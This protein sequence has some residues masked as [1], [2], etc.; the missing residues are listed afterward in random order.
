MPRPPSSA[1]TLALL[2]PLL[3]LAACQTPS[4]PIAV[5][6]ADIRQMILGRWYREDFALDGEAPVSHETIMF[7]ADG[8]CRYVRSGTAYYPSGKPAPWR[9]EQ[10]G[11]WQ[12]GNRILKRTWR[13]TSELPARSEEG[14]VLALSAEELR[15]REFPFNHFDNYYRTIRI[16]SVKTNRPNRAIEPTPPD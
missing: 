6:D 14:E 8:S 10:R 15:L 5:S 11:E 9:E 1:S 7:A 16:R 12:L 3:C 13:A 2:F 4:T